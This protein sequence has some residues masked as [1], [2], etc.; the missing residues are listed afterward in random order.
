[1]KFLLEVSIK[2]GY[3]TLP[4]IYSAFLESVSILLQHH[5][6]PFVLFIV[7]NRCMG[8]INFHHFIW[9]VLDKRE[10]FRTKS[11]DW[12]LQILN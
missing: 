6:I 4:I 8:V 11:G 7:E 2:T 12:L 9:S 3:I 5:T 1:M 10:K